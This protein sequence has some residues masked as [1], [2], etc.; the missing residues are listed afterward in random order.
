[1][2]SSNVIDHDFQVRREPEA[3]DSSLH[4]VRSHRRIG[5]IGGLFSAPIGPGAESSAEPSW[6]AVR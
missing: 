3:A 6:Q 5:G 4:R 1:M 2:T